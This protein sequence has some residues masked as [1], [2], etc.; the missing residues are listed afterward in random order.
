M[1]IEE[2]NATIARLYLEGH[3]TPT[4][5]RETG[6]SLPLIFVILKEL[7]ITGPGGPERAKLSEDRN[8]SISPLH[9]KLGGRLYSYRQFDLC[10]DRNQAAALLGWTVKKLALVEKGDTQLTL[11]ELAAMADFM[12]VNLATL[13]K[14]L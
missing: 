8:K 4:I 1:D 11:T 9:V 7:K 6:V 5:S 2:R 12:K 14:D 3:S 13:L 10:R